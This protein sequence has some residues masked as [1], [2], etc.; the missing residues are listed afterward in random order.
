MKEHSHT[1]KREGRGQ[2]W[3]EGVRCGNQEVGSHGMGF[4]GRDNQ[5]VNII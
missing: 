2:I 3:D 4:G 1:V 5:E